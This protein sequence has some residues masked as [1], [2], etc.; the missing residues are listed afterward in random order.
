MGRISKILEQTAISTRIV[1]DYDDDQSESKE[2]DA[3]L[4]KIRAEMLMDFDDKLKKLR[5]YLADVQ[6]RRTSLNLDKMATLV[7]YEL[8]KFAQEF[9]AL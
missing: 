3:M 6:K 9:K 4:D 2:S 1:N 8:E 7:S 5:D